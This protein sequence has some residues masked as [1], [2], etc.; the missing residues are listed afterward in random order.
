MLNGRL[1][2]DICPILR[3]ALPVFV[4]CNVL[5]E[6]LSRTIPA[7][8]IGD[9]A[10]EMFGVGAGAGGGLL[11]PPP[12]HATRSISKM[13]ATINFLKKQIYT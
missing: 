1:G 4:I 10:R 3:F 9:G 11:S 13:K 5:S 2:C 12:P 8:S 6:L 7:K